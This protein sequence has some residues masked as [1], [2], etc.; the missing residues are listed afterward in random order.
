M[1]TS[2]YRHALLFF[3][4]LSLSFATS[5]VADQPSQFVDLSLM[6]S[7]EYPC[8]WPDFSPPFRLLPEHRIGRNSA[9]N[10]DSIMIDGN[11]GTQMDVP[12]H[13]VTRP[14]LGLPNGGRFG[15][16]FSEKAPPWKFAGEACVVDLHEI[17][18]DAPN[19]V[20]PRILK[21]H[22]LDW[23]RRHREFHAGDV[24]LFH[25]GYTDAY[26]LPLPA[27]RR[28]IAEVMEQKAPGFPGPEVDTMEYLAGQR[29]VRHIGTD[30]PSMGTLPDIGEP[31]HYAALKHGAV[32]TEGA[33][34]L[35]QLPKTGAFYCMLSRKNQGGPYTE[36]RAFAIVGGELPERLIESVRKKQAVD[37][38]VINSIDL[39]LTWPGKGTGY[40]RQRFARADFL[41]SDNLQLYHH[42]HMMDSMA[43]TH[44][45]P[46]AY[47]LPAEKL[48]PNAYAPEV[49]VWLEEYER[50]YGRRG[51]S[52]VTT[53]KVP[54]S[55]TCGWARVMDVRH[56]VG[57]TNRAD[58][59]A[60]PEI[61]VDEITKY[62]AAH[63][64]LAPGEIVILFTGHNDRH[65]R[66]GVDGN[67]CMLNPINGKSEGWPAAGPDAIA[68]L[69]QRG[70]R[71]V[72]T[73]APS[74]GGVEPKRA[75]M[76]YW[77]LGSQAMAGVEFLINVGQLPERSYFL[78][79]AVKIKGCHGGPGR[80]IALY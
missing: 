74:L 21:K 24:V 77:M 62:E 32:F 60:S 5:A 57:S 34:G 40:S 23:E 73:D 27:G 14:E 37:L 29:H 18:D 80:A 10:I 54:L 26:Y 48:S 72:A 25:S 65:F 4:G 76:T 6:I 41:F 79:A 43:G 56:L 75:M 78:F 58:W 42:G 63:G 69:A 3:L 53:E 15:T 39:P 71:C 67:A 13:S 33:I 31:V 38:S 30:S 68:Y 2:I 51:E 64:K 9:Y 35:G 1:W 47:A 22:V 44:L 11:C 55:Q 61:T 12:A 28:M 19:G 7:S 20:S 50:Q 49:H 8:Y 45:V 46:P 59:P 16:E 36:G 17:R 52:D 66:S 70:I